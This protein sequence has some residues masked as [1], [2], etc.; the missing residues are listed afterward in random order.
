MQTTKILSTVFG[1]T[2]F[3]FLLT[4]CYTRFGL[5]ER[6][7]GYDYEEEVVYE[8]EYYEDTETVRVIHYYGVP[9][10]FSAAYFYYDPYDYWYWEPGITITVGAY[11]GPPYVYR[12]YP[13][14]WYPPYGPCPPPYVYGGWHHYPGSL[15]L[16]AALC[17]LHT[18]TEFTKF[19]TPA[20]IHRRS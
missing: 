5:V 12:S 10:H 13:P 3:A 17:G 11:Y 16:S 2:M 1:L 18:A 7:A 15:A 6:D 4:G 19:W 9:R 14:Y 8:D 20:Q